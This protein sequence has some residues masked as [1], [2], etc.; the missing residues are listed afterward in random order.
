MFTKNA[1]KKLGFSPKFLKYLAFCIRN[2]CPSLRMSRQW[3]ISR[4]VKLQL[5]K[6]LHRCVPL[7]DA[8]LAVCSVSKNTVYS[9]FYGPKAKSYAACW[10]QFVY[11]YEPEVVFGTRKRRMSTCSWTMHRLFRSGW[12]TQACNSREC[13][14]CATFR[15]PPKRDQSIGMRTPWPFHFAFEHLPTSKQMQPYLGAQV[16]SKHKMY[17]V[18]IEGMLWSSARTQTQNW[19]TPRAP[20]DKSV[21]HFAKKWTWDGLPRQRKQGQSW[22]HS[23]RRQRSLKLQVFCGNAKCAKRYPAELNWY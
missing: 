22:T 7:V 4:D 8:V 2:A 9:L 15:P 6:A 16:S 12:T 13:N 21:P 3:G 19:N 1:K 11:E 23:R 20:H 5:A 17:K 18:L 14:S 10:N